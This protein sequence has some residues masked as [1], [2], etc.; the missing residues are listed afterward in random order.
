MS[1]QELKEEAWRQKLKQKPWKDADYRFSL[2]DLHRYLYYRVHA[3]LPRDGTVGNVVTL[4][5]QGATN[6]T[7][8]NAPTKL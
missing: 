8:H 4:P 2:P 5:Q 6:K 3:K 1:G 7:P